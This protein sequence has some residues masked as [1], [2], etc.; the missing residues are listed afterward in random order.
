MNELKK[1]AVV[2]GGTMGRQIGLNAAI[3]GYNTIVCETVPAVRDNLKAWEEGYLA[4]RIAKGKMTQEDLEAVHARMLAEIGAAGGR[5]DAI[6]TC[7]ELAPDHP[8][9]KP[10]TGMF[11][12]AC[13]D[14][15]DIDPARS[16]MLGDSDYDRDFAANCGMR[17]VRMETAEITLSR[18]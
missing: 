14:Y 17:F 11:L 1:C 7:A 3:H 10:Q 6:Y 2:G 4:G 13:Q 18:R 15:P 8:M 9:R 16:L 12:A 5:I